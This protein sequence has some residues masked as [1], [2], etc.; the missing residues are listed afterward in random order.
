VFVSTAARQYNKLHYY[1][2]KRDKN[3]LFQNIYFESRTLSQSTSKTIFIW[4]F[5]VVALLA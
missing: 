4:V 3:S 1:R 2:R 5:Y